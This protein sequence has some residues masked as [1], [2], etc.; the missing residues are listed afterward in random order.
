MEQLTN[1]SFPLRKPLRGFRVYRVMKVETLSRIKTFGKVLTVVGVLMMLL[2]VV[3]GVS[4]MLNPKGL[5][6]L[7][8]LVMAYVMTLYLGFPLLI[9]GLIAYFIGRRRT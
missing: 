4:A 9:I 7:A 8:V 2:G 1:K 3:L 5:V 6:S